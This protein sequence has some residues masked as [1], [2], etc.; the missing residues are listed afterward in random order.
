MPDNKRPLSDL[1]SDLADVVG[2]LYDENVASPEA[3]IF[4]E[5]FSALTKI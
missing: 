2:D 1:L 5:A 3:P 4:R